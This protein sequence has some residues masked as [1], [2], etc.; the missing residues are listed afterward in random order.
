MA[1]NEDGRVEVFTLRPSGS[2]E[3]IKS[4]RPSVGGSV[5]P[6]Q[7]PETVNENRP[8]PPPSKDE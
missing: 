1:K 6:P 3:L 4:F 7:A 2:E 5:K 8:P